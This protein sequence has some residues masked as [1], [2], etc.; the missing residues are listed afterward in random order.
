MDFY[1]HDKKGITAK[2]ET[3]EYDP[4]RSA[5]ISLVC[6]ADGE[7]RYI[8]AHKDIK[9]DDVII[10]DEKAKLV[11]GNRMKIS[12]IPTGLQIYNLEMIVNKGASSIRSAGSYGT[13]VS[14]EGR[15]TQV[16]M[17]S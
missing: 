7:R 3:I 14:Q 8:L 6:Y 11:A 9:V 1:F 15:Y 13:V 4:Y 17:P 2:V 12:N 10:T 16:K 5:W